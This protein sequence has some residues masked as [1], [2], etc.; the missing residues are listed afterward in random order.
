MKK[1]LWQKIKA[2][3]CSKNLNAPLSKTSAMTREPQLGEFMVHTP[4][5]TRGMVSCIESNKNY[6]ETTLTISDLFTGKTLVKNAARQEF[7]Y[8]QTERYGVSYQ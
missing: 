5:G 3:I 1:S 4:S 2:Y 6:S 7:R 8:I